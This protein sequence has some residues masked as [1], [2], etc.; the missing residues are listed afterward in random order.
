MAGVT[1]RDYVAALKRERAYVAQLEESPAQALRLRDC[2]TELW[3]F[4]GEV[5]EGT[6]LTEADKKKITET[7]SGGAQ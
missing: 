3:G 6:T 2:D 7:R 1:R 4:A 5:V